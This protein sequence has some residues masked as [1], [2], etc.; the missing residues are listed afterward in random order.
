MQCF[1]VADAG[2]LLPADL[3][4]TRPPAA[5][6]PNYVLSFD[7]DGAH[8]NLW[9]F[10]VDWNNAAN[11]TFTK[12]APIAVKRFTPACNACIAQPPGGTTLTS[13][14]DR[15]MY[16]LAYRQFADH[17]SLVVNHTVSLSGAVGPTGIRWYELRN[18]DTAPVVFQ[19]STYAPSTAFRWIGSV[20]MDK[21]GNMLL[22]YS[23]SSGTIVPSI[24][25]ASRLASD[26]AG[27]LSAEKIVLA[28][29]G[30]QTDPNRWGDYASVTLDPV[31]DCTFYFA[32]QFLKMKGRYNWQTN[33][34]RFRF[35]GCQ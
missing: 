12:A 17:E 15:L 34:A 24:G 8:L 25:F 10:H 29:T 27:T 4:G 3:D 19:Q 14:G 1:D 28:G 26:P 9:K 11:S 31:D 23:V 30:V 22:G 5:G 2:G 6:T 32:T 20:A 16:R 33:I 21:S 35:P 13:L 18:L 7:F